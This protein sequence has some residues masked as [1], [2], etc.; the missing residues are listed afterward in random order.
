M[1]SRAPLIIVP[2]AGFGRRVGSPEAKELLPGPNG[3]PMIEFVLEIARERNWP[4]HVIT[5]PEKTSLVEYLENLNH[6]GHS[7]SI[8]MTPPTPDWPH[9]L[10]STA[11]H[12]RETNLVF[13]PD[14]IFAPIQTV[15]RIQ[16][17]L[18]ENH[19]VAWA[20]HYVEN[21]STWGVIESAGDRTLRIGEKPQNAGPGWCWGFF[22]F[23][24]DAGEQ[25]L[26]AQ[27]L[28]T[29]DHQWQSLNL[30]GREFQL[31]EFQDLTR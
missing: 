14:T 22:G 12:W 4:V 29:L 20:A 27:S 5:R 25:L 1:P 15:D 23:Q 17:A 31:T 9:T 30:K 16:A 10:L 18:S 11:P 6:H 13:L 8:Q 19:Q 2:A 28:S 24:R 21:R 7:I 26:K 3:R